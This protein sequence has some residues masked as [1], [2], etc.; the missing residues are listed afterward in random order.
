[1]HNNGYFSGRCSGNVLKILFM[2]HLCNF[3]V[4]LV[5]HEFVLLIKVLFIDLNHCRVLLFS[6]IIRSRKIPSTQYQNINRH[7]MVDVIIYKVET[8]YFVDGYFFTFQGR[9]QAYLCLPLVQRC[10]EI[11]LLIDELS[12][13]EL[14]Y[15]FPILIDS[16][17]GITDNVG[18]GLH[19][20]CLKRYPQEYEVLCN[21]LSP[22]GPLFSICYKLL[23]DCYLKYNFPV[24]YLPV[25]IN[26]L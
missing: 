17:F 11:A 25:S 5:V 7:Y 10:R 8:M 16:L 18:W 26:E 12:I 21:F 6:Q 20:I 3:E 14:H 9:F 24:S 4:K 13:T 23:P 19:S 1:M 15:V 2:N 22:Q